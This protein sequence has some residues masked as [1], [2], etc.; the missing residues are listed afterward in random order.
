VQYNSTESTRGPSP[1][2]YTSRG[3][4]VFQTRSKYLML[5]YTSSPHSFLYP[6]ETLLKWSSGLVLFS[7]K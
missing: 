2:S 3:F 1:S 4:L 5:V 6:M 7:S